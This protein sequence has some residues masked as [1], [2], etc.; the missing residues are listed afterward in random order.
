MF[1]GE[2]PL[3]RMVCIRR[4][5]GGIYVD[6]E[7]EPWERLTY[8]GLRRKSTS[9]RVSLTVFAQAKIPDAMP[10]ASSADA[11]ISAGRVHG[12][13]MPDDQDSKRHRADVPE[14]QQ[15]SHHNI[16]DNHNLHNHNSNNLQTPTHDMTIPN[17]PEPMKLQAQTGEES[18]SQNSESSA[19][20]T[21]GEDRTMIDLVSNKHGPKFLALSSSDQAWLLKIHRNLGHPGSPKLID[22]CR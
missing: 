6:E 21:T 17:L 18:S 15:Q 8:E 7:W 16:T 4:R 1:P 20:K 2:A 5:V 19:I 10:D 3:R 14:V 11:P 13:D 9:A 22:F 12:M